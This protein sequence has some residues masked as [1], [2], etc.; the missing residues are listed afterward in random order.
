MLLLLYGYR[1]TAAAVFSTGLTGFEP[2]TSGVTDRHSN[3]LS[4]SP[5]FAN[6]YTAFSCMTFVHCL[7]QRGL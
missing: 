2:A 3:Q 1:C 4:Y 6:S 5:L 7:T